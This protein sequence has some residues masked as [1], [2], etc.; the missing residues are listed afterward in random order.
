[1]D[2][3]VVVSHS[4]TST[5]TLVLVVGYNTIYQWPRPKNHTLKGNTQW[6]REL[7]VPDLEEVHCI[8]GWLIE[9]VCDGFG[10][11]TRQSSHRGESVGVRDHELTKQDIGWEIHVVYSG[12]GV[13]ATPRC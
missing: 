8:K 4:D 13:S 10:R 6:A 5:I 1:M 2:R 12:S 9:C 7:L 11:S 3:D